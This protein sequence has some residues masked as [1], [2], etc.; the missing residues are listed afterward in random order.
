MISVIIPMYNSSKTI[1]TTLDSIKNQTEFNK[2]LE[3]II[4]NDG[5]TD[6]SLE[7]VQEYSKKN[8]DMPIFIV[9]KSNGGVSSAR[10]VGLKMAKGDLIALLDSDDVWFKNKIERQLIVMNENPD[11]DFLGCDSG[12]DGLKILNKKINYL[13]KANIKELCI[14]CFPSTPT[15]LFKRKIIEEIGYFDE[16]KRYGE[17]MNYFN[18]I[19]IKYNYY[20]LPEHLVDIGGGKPAFGHSGLSGNLRGMHYGHLDNIKELR[21]GKYISLSFYYLMYNYYW[22]KYFR[23]II[24]TKLRKFK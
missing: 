19:C 16:N 11:I 3:I 10:N 24:I 9:N 21:E 5:S 4:I 17:D 22:I 14:K 15:V 18:K 12:K 7:I 23:R 13:H 1:E 20:Y 2:I 6:N 8:N